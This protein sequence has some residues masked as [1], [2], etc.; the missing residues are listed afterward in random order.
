M[1]DV[2]AITGTY[3]TNHT[4]E[5]L[6]SLCDPKAFVLLLGGTAPLSPV[7]FEF[8]IDAI[9]GTR[10]I[11]SELTLRYASQGA[12]FKQMKKGIRLLTLL[13]NRHV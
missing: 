5:H 11:D 10:V 9:S 1:A 7:L 6:L 12:S 13:K 8:G 3:L 4:L 2:V